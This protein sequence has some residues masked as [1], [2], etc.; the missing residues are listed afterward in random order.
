MFGLFKKKKNRSENV[1]KG[2]EQETKDLVLTASLDK[3]VRTVE[4]LFEDVDILR[5]RRVESNFDS[6]LRYCMIYCDGVVNS[7]A[8]NENLVKPL[9]LSRVSPSGGDFADTVIRRIV[10]ICDA[11]KTDSFQEIVES[12]SYGNTALFIEGQDRAVLL[13]TKSFQTRSTAEPD[14]EKGLLGPRDGF[15]ESLLGNL[16]LIRRRMLTSDL[17]MKSMTL[18]TRT[19]TKVYV[20]YMDSIVNKQILAE[21]YSRLEPIDIDGILD[22][23]YITEQVM[24]SPWSPFRTV[25]YTERPDVVMGKLLEGRIA[26][27]VDG[28]PVVLTVPYLFIENFQSSE[29]Y[30]MNFF[31]S[32]FSRMLRII[33]FL[34]TITVPGLYISVAAFHHEMFPLQLFISIAAERQSVPLPAAMEAFVMLVLFDILKETGARMPSTIG[35]ALSIVG[36]LVIGQAAVEAQLVAAPMVIVI[37]LTGITGLLVPKLNAPT[38]Y[39][40]IILLI[41]SSMFGFFGLMLGLT[42]VIIHILNLYSFG[43]P[44]IMLSRKLQYQNVKDTFIRAPW[45]QMIRRPGFAADKIRQSRK[46][47]RRG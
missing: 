43:V 22:V 42:C 2:A 30:Y 21:L 18:G 7:D 14:N 29:D 9:M 44:Q 11:K 27:F 40:R 17:K 37:A 16:S 15:T 10:Q 46:G 31:Y 28:T 47:A 36:A 5:V 32:S 25:G 45:W 38:I 26:L 24:D 19:R 13:D 35:Q 4:K 8:I 3:N 6:D 41:L 34:L 23:N 39:L 1:E 12:V 20:C 33:G